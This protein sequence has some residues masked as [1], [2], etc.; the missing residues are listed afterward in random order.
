MQDQRA[1]K[2]DIH[3]HE[4][5]I[6]LSLAVFSLSFISTV[7]SFKYSNEIKKAAVIFDASSQLTD[8]KYQVPIRAVNLFYS[9]ASIEAEK[10]LN[11]EESFQETQGLILNMSKEFAAAAD[12]FDGSSQFADAYELTGAFSSRYIAA[13]DI[14]DGSDQITDISK[15]ITGNITPALSLFDASDQITG[16]RS[17]HTVMYDS[18]VAVLDLFDATTLSSRQIATPPSEVRN[19]AP[20]QVAGE[21]INWET[22]TQTSPGAE[23][24][25]EIAPSSAEATEGESS[26]LEEPE[27]PRNGEVISEPGPQIEQPAIEPEE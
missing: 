27:A 3:H 11:A 5:V 6:L 22:P 18:A 26:A 20:G 15:R 17:Y 19:G 25:E 24:A 12:I 2:Q 4:L 10:L 9:L 1:T 16:I 13:L 7:M 8:D 23:Q 14:F 21:E